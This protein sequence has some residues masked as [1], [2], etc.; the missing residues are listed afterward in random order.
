M[1]STVMTS[2]AA[3]AVVVPMLVVASPSAEAGRHSAGRYSGSPSRG[4]TG[5]KSS[6]P[7]ILRQQFNRTTQR[8]ARSGNKHS[9]VTRPAMSQQRLAPKLGPPPGPPLNNMPTSKSNQAIRQALNPPANGKMPT[10]A[11]QPI[12]IPAEGVP[13][14]GGPVLGGSGIQPPLAPIPPRDTAKDPASAGLMTPGARGPGIGRSGKDLAIGSGFVPNPR[15]R[16]VKEMGGGGPVGAI[17]QAGPGT[18]PGKPNEPG[19]PG[20]GGTPGPGSPGTPGTPGAPGT[21]GTADAPG[22]TPPDTAP[23]VRSPAIV[24][25][26]GV[27]FGDRQAPAVVEYVPRYAAPRRQPQP[28]PQLQPAKAKTD[29][30]VC[31]EGAWAMQDDQKKYVCLSWYFRGRIYTPDQMAQILAQLQPQAQ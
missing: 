18:G 29:E 9:A 27:G 26:P 16:S 8:T 21:P 10:P 15:P 6:R 17:K 5:F 23:S 24:V 1:Y 12:P 30:P 3:L 11:G 14:P 20:S 25:V 4:A 13:R 31:V 19:I 22:G 28:Q 2:V 7:M